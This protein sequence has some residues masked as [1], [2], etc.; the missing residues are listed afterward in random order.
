MPNPR[1]AYGP[2][3]VCQTE[4]HI[5]NFEI[6]HVKSWADG[7]SD[8]L[9]NLRPICTPCNRSMGRENLYVYKKRFFPE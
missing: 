7:G 4:I 3:L 8:R 6:G 2:C 9:E 5:L 1:S